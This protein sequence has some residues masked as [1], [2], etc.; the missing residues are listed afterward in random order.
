[1]DSLLERCLSGRKGRFAK[2]LYVETCIEG[3]NPS[4]S[5]PTCAHLPSTSDATEG[6]HS[7]SFGELGKPHVFGEMSERFNVPVSKTGVLSKVPGVRIPLSPLL[8]F[9]FSNNLRYSSNTNI[10]FLL[11]PVR[12]LR[13]SRLLKSLIS[14]FAVCLVTSRFVI[15][16]ETVTTG[17]VTKY[18]SNDFALWDLLPNDGMSSFSI[19][20]LNAIILVNVSFGDWFFYFS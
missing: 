7:A 18:V 12:S 15:T 16:S 11:Y 13:M 6:R 8:N 20:S 4:L 17:L 9:Y 2:P 10:L 5:A 19:L 3:S 1:M 14:A